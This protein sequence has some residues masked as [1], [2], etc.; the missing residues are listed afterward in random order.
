MIESLMTKVPPLDFSR[1]Y[2]GD[3][4]IDIDSWNHG[5]CCTPIQ[6]PQLLV[7]LTYV[8]IKFA[9]LGFRIWG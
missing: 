6:N 5:V 1:V 3:G 2:M 8:Y 7:W 4:D 9:G